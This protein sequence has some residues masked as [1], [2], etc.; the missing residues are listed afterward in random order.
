MSKPWELSLAVREHRSPAFAKAANTNLYAALPPEPE[1]MPNPL[2]ICLKSK[3]WEGLPDRLLCF[4]IC[5]AMVISLKSASSYPHNIL[6]KLFNPMVLSALVCSTLMLMGFPID[7]IKAIVSAFALVGVVKN[8]HT[9]LHICRIMSAVVT[10]I[11]LNNLIPD[12]LAIGIALMSS[13][14]PAFPRRKCEGLD[15]TDCS[16]S[17]TSPGEGA[18]SSVGFTTCLICDPDRLAAACAGSKH[19]KGSV[20]RILNKLEDAVREQVLSRIP[21][22]LRGHFLHP[23]QDLC[24]GFAGL[25][26]CFSASGGQMRIHALGQ[27]RCIFCD[28]Q[29]LQAE[30]QEA[31]GCDKV[32]QMLIACTAAARILAIEERIPAD[33]RD[34]FRAAL[35]EP[36]VQQQCGPG[37]K[38]RRVED[39]D[40]QATHER[41]AAALRCRQRAGLDWGAEE[42]KKYRSHVLDDRCRVRN[43]M[44]QEKIRIAP[45]AAV[46]NETSLPAASISD[47]AVKLERWCLYSSWAMCRSCKILQPRDL[48]DVVLD[49]D[50][51]VFINVNEC[52]TCSAK[53]QLSTLTPEDVPQELRGLSLET[54]NA[55]A[56]LE[57]R[58]GAYVRAMRGR[59]ETGYR[60]KTG[61][62][63]FAWHA[64]SVQHRIDALAD[65]DQRERASKAFQLLRASP[66][67]SY[68]KWYQEHCQYL[69]DH[70]DADDTSRLRRME[71]IER[72]ELETAAWPLLFWDS[73]LCYSHYRATDSRRAHRQEAAEANRWGLFNVDDD[74]EDVNPDARHSTK[75]LFA[76]Q[77][78]MPLLGMAN[79]FEII[80]YVYDCNLWTALCSKRQLGH[81]IPMR[82]MMKG[83]P[84]S[85]LYWKSVHHGL[86]DF[87][88]QVGL[89]KVFWTLAPYVWSYPMHSFVKDEMHK[90]LRQRLHLPVAETLHMVHTILQIVKHLLGGSTSQ[91][92]CSKHKILQAKREDGT[93]YKIHYVCRLEYQDGSRKKA[94]QDYHGSGLPHVHVLLFFDDGALPALKLEDKV[95]GSDPGGEHPHLRGYVIG[96]QLDQDGKSGWPI[97]EGPSGFDQESRCFRLQH[98][99]G[100]SA[101]GLRAYI[102]E[103]MDVLR[104]HQDFLVSDDEY[105]ILRAYVTKYVSKFSDSAQEE[106]LNDN[107][108]IGSMAATVLNR[109]KPYEPEIVLQLCGSKFRQW[110]MS[111]SSGGKRSFVVPLPD[112]DHQPMEVMHYLSSEWACGY[113]SLNDFLRKTNAKGKICNWLKK[114]HENTETED[115]L[116]EFACSYKMRG[117]KVVAA[118]ML[119]RLND[120]YYGQWVLLHVPFRELRELLDVA[121]LDRVPV[122]YKYMGMALKC[123]HAVACATWQHPEVIQGDMRMESHSQYHIDTV[124]HMIACHRQL[125]DDYI[126]GK[127]DAAAERQEREARIQD[128]SEDAITDWNRQQTEYKDRLKEAIDRA[129]CVQMDD[130]EEKAE[131]AR[132]KAMTSNKALVAF[133][134]PGTG[135]TA[136]TFAMIDYC[137]EHNGRVL[138]SLPTAAL[139]SRMRERYGNRID[140]DTCAASFKLME[141]DDPGSMPF[142]AMY[143]LIVIDE[144]SQ[145]EG[146]QSDYILK[147]WDHTERIP[148]LAIMGDRYQ[149]AGFGEMRPWHTKLWLQKTW[150]KEFFQVYRCKDPEFQKILDTLRTSMPDDALLHALASKVWWGQEPS[151]ANVR[152]LLHAHP[153]TTVLTCSRWGSKKV[154]DCALLALFPKFPPRAVVPGDVES[155]PVNYHQGQIKPARELQPQDVPIFIG[156]KVYLTRNVNKG[157][158]YVNGMRGTVTGFDSKNGGVQVLTATNHRITVYPWT[159][160]DLGNLVYYPLRPGYASTI[161]KFQGS[162]LSHVTVFLDAA[163]V[164]GAAYTAMSRVEFG[165]QVVLAGALVAEHFTP[166]C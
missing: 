99:P 89:P 154:N 164:P 64:D 88:K 165:N 76:V 156:M 30:C 139:A 15:G 155:N 73:S 100:D 46:S 141:R 74:D 135:K 11:L 32:M 161:L 1:K 68:D 95:S 31:E 55:I 18:Q 102:L 58:T 86:T 57:V 36:E 17:T 140:I 110:M 33:R 96:S 44:K 136:A 117:E 98:L 41:W 149:M 21:L 22:A 40:V 158:D 142:L 163:N 79:R 47:T 104:C 39:V 52:K 69:H 119:S 8:V 101:V 115:S 166:A 9:D 38:K 77:A 92:G 111:T 157:I 112:A 75:H 42:Q 87:V 26:C 51:D 48:S 54:C 109:Y 137:L 138:F 25:E 43:K 130:D 126:S 107:A 129:L 3:I 128:K 152:K 50:Q 35:A 45:G 151:V 131:E 148:A 14:W 113:I 162:Q 91:R 2:P 12:P 53:A 27:H 10:F 61:I 90:E 5:L 19:H 160:T 127:L 146:W 23:S 150:R 66:D 62:I 65:V 28:T 70:P 93:E 114:I 20:T 13:V 159:D 97:H 71:F 37:V 85:P 147:L 81:E 67:C 16:F 59:V 24:Q 29:R 63:R 108:S 118:E 120:R 103:I 34:Q 132:S 94:T 144:I 78:M 80:Q 125:I 84:F 153:D 83:H 105:G 56:L 143:T 121:E 106:W 4:S 122:E 133:G 145:L 72:I 123:R 124:M 60:Q 82:I 6:Y 116:E 7:K 134:P 49:K